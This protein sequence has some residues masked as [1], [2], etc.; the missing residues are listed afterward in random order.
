MEQNYFDQELGIFIFCVP[1]TIEKQSIDHQLHF[2]WF[3]RALQ[4]RHSTVASN[5]C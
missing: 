5:A 4:Q 1:A 2:F 3:S